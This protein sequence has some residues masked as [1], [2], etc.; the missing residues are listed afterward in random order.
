MSSTPPHGVAEAPGVP[1]EH[2]DNGV[3]H[4]GWS[5]TQA[6][7]D[8]V[9]WWRSFGRVQFVVDRRH[10][11]ARGDGNR[12]LVADGVVAVGPVPRI[13]VLVPDCRPR[14]DRRLFLAPIPF[15]STAPAATRG[16][17]GYWVPTGRFRSPVLLGCSPIKLGQRL[18]RSAAHQR[19]RVLQER[20]NRSPGFWRL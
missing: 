17:E 16:V 6:E 8:A 14:E 15:Q 7:P 2:T 18:L 3:Q 11:R 5:T 1:D 20:L 10:G 13:G 9:P 4:G 19:V 12:R